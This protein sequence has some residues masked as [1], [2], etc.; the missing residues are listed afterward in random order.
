[1]DELPDIAGLVDVAPA[2][3]LALRDR[4]VAIGV[5]AAHVAP[6]LALSARFSEDDRN[7]IRLWHLRRRDDAAA[8]AMRLLMF[9]DMLTAKEAIEALGEPLYSVL[10]DAGLLRVDDDAVRCTLRL[11][12]AGEFHLF[13]DELAPGGDAVM[14]MRDTTIPLWRAI[15]P[16]RMVDRVLDIGCGAGALA[17]LLCRHAAQVVASDINPRAVALARINVALNGI[18]NIDV[19]EGD[20]FAPVDGEEFDL[21]AAHTAYVALPEGMEGAS[22]CMAGGAATRWCAA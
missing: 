20:M 3:W 10:A 7:P 22:H 1:M 14:G 21:I 9:G 4:L 11:A 15:A 18:D 8:L 13:G 6:I 12:M 5:D 2:D 19:R 16:T 17:L